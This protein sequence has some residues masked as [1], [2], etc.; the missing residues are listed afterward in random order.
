MDYASFDKEKHPDLHPIFGACKV[1]NV[2]MLKQHLENGISVYIDHPM[3]PSLGAIAIGENNPEALQI[4]IDSGLDINH[5]LN[6]FGETLLLRA[7]SEDRMSVIE[8]LL[9]WGA[10]VNLADENGITP[11]IAASTNGNIKVIELLVE[12]GADMEIMSGRGR[13]ALME[14]VSSD[15]IVSISWWVSHGGDIEYRDPAGNSP[16]IVAAKGGK[17]AATQWLVEHGADIHAKDERGNTALDWAKANGHSSI[18]K[19]LQSRTGS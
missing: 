5:S 15:Q 16:I 14:A 3:H 12:H 6:R 13:T 10:N 4:L 11:L 18:V 19:L 8:S 1:G 17:F 9:K 7:I 2:K